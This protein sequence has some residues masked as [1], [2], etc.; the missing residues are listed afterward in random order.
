MTENRNLFVGVLAFVVVPLSLPLLSLIA[1]D[2]TSSK[3][4]A[5]ASGTA[6]KNPVAANQNPIT[7]GQKIHTKRCAGCH[8]SFD[9]G[10]GP[11]AV[12]LGIHPAKLS[13]VRTM[14]P[15]ARCF[16]KLLPGKSQCRDMARDSPKP[17]DGT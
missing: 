11:N 15:M 8:G 10:D 6:R 7:A 4:T 9:N 2:S 1:A 16:G 5:P 3:W 13:Q 12:D 14:N 17:T